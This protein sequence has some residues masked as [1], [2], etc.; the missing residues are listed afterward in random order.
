MFSVRVNILKKIKIDFTYGAV[1]LAA[2]MIIGGYSDM[3]IPLFTAAA[4]HELGHISAIII[5]GGEISMLTVNAGGLKIDYNS[6]KFT[7]LQDIICAA[8]GPL[9]G[10]IAAKLASLLGFTVLSGISFVISI[11]NLLPVRPLD[12]GKILYNTYLLLFESRAEHLTVITEVATLTLLWIISAA[13]AI[14]S[15]GNISMCCIA[16]VLTFYYCKDR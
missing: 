6:T 5:M 3:I 11:F 2:T 1:I 12:G 10:L 15:K 13:S 16:L 8:S 4:I 14:Y 7:Y 9:M